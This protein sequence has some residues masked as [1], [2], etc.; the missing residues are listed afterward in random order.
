MVI[1]GNEYLITHV[2]SMAYISVFQKIPM[3]GV[4]I[5]A[6]Q[7]GGV[8]NK[9]PGSEKTR[10]QGSFGPSTGGPDLQGSLQPAELTKAPQDFIHVKQLTIIKLDNYLDINILKR[11]ELHI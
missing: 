10:G 8:S 3:Q 7:R 9:P 5:V 4:H 11:N 2:H 6:C 1:E